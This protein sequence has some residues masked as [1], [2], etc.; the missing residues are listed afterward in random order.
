MQLG[1]AISKFRYVNMLAVDGKTDLNQISL[2]GSYGQSVNVPSASSDNPC[3]PVQYSGSVV[4]ENP[5][6]GIH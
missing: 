3:N 2:H 4:Y 5:D 6:Y 1:Q